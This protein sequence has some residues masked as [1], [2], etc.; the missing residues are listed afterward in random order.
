MPRTRAL[1]S[2]PKQDLQPDEAVAALFGFLVTVA[3]VVFVSCIGVLSFMGLRK[4]GVSEGWSLGIIIGVLR[5]FH[6][7]SF[8]AYLDRQKSGEV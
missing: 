8:A 2:K 1:N 6:I 5:L 4:I 3:N 7:M